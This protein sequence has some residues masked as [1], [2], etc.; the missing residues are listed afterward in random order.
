MSTWYFGGRGEPPPVE[1]KI[2]SLRIFWP[3]RP[4]IGPNETEASFASVSARVAAPY[5]GR[6]PVLPSQAASVGA[7]SI[8]TA[9]QR[10]VPPQV[11]DFEA[12]EPCPLGNHIHDPLRHDDHLLHR[13]PAQS[14]DNRLQFQ[15]CC[16]DFSGG[17]VSGDRQLVPALTIHLYGNGDRIVNEKGLLHDRPRLICKQGVVTKPLP[18]FFSQMRHHRAEHLHENLKA[19]ANSPV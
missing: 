17:R 5:M 1:W 7:R 12:E 10:A 16:L 6:K 18:A 4:G 15:G 13:P 19:L 9:I 2:S 11:H 8:T 3:T 14:S